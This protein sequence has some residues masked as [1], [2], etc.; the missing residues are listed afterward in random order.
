MFHLPKAINIWTSP[1]KN[2]IA[3]YEKTYDKIDDDHYDFDYAGLLIEPV[4]LDPIYTSDDGDAKLCEVERLFRSLEN[5]CAD[6]QKTVH[7]DHP[8]KMLMVA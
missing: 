2:G 8:T 1:G 3:N 4:S 7:D 5:S 6:H